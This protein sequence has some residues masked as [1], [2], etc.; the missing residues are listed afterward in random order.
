M[1]AQGRAHHLTPSRM[2]QGR[3]RARE[4]A[5]GRGGLLVT[6]AMAEHA[7]RN[8]LYMHSQVDP[9]ANGSPHYI[10]AEG[11]HL[12][13][14]PNGDWAINGAFDPANP[15]CAVYA[16]SNSGDAV[17]TGEVEW[18]YHKHNGS[19]ETLTVVNFSLRAMTVTK[20]SEA[21]AVAAVAQA[22]ETVHMRTRPRASPL[23]YT[24]KRGSHIVVRRC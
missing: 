3:A 18:W 11:M 16:D 14:L 17:P 22:K 6:G 5:E 2:P 23:M 10:S 7:E 12:Y 9:Y 1:C 24:C 15:A 13:V 4:Q 21:E 8:G 20:L 19:T